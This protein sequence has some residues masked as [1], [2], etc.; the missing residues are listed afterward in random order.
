MWIWN[1]DYNVISYNFALCRISR[2]L[3]WQSTINRL[4]E[5]Q[6]ISPCVDHPVLHHHHHQHQEQPEQYQYHSTDGVSSHWEW[7]TLKEMFAETW[8][9]IA[10]IQ[11]QFQLPQF[12]VRVMAILCGLI[13]DKHKTEP[14]HHTH[15]LCT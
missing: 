13:N 8:N 9:F 2:Q 10:S 15:K 12:D 14:H 5:M 4:L 6:T 1:V 7:K 3:I 11:N